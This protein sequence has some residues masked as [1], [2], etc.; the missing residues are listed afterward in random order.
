VALRT[1]ARCAAPVIVGGAVDTGGAAGTVAVAELA[2]LT[3]PSGFDA[4]T[5]T[6]RIA[7][8]SAVPIV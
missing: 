1:P 8:S 6:R 3:A 2:A 4:L 5:F 7:F